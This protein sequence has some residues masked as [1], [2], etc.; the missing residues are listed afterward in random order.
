M[1][2]VMEIHAYTLLLSGSNEGFVRHHRSC[3]LDPLN[4]AMMSFFFFSSAGGQETDALFV[5]Q[6][7][8]KTPP[9][10]A[11]FL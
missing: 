11:F 7:G 9:P 8:G 4:S 3:T 6:V 2:E 1:T 5:G 10:P